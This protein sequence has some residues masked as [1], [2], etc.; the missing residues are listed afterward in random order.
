VHLDLIGGLLS[1]R[2][3]RVLEIRPRTGMISEGLRRLYGAEVHTMPIWESQRFLLKEVY[4]IESSGL[5]DYDQFDI[6]DA[7]PFDLIICNH[8]L[9]HAVRPERFFDAVHR[10]LVDG[11][12]VYLYNEPDD[13]EYLAGN[14]SMFATLNPLHMQAF[15]QKSLARAL[16][17]NGF[18]IVFQRRRNESHIC[19][20]KRRGDTAR[21]NATWTPMTAKERDKRVRAYRRARD[22]AILA[23]RGDL[24]TRFAD[25]WP[26]VVQRGVAEGLVDFDADGNLRLVAR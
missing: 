15:D 2:N 21:L 22:R 4:G 18:D 23:V 8:M 7:G 3:A 6:P 9:T 14:Q 25:E 13:A 19:L 16:M 20:A 12:H 26:Q 24:R 11:G 1:P 5:V 17:A 10:R